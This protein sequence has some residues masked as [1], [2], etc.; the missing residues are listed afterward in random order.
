VTEDRNGPSGE[1]LSLAL[2]KKGAE[3]VR[4]AL[5]CSPSPL[6]STARTT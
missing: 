2:E 6:F 1:L 3:R 4:A 5:T